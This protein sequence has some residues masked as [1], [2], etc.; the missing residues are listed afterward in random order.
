M[1]LT[2]W[3]ISFFFFNFF[4]LSSVLCKGVCVLLK[5]TASQRPFS[6]LEDHVHKKTRSDYRKELV[7]VESLAILYL[8]F[9][10]VPVCKSNLGHCS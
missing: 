9:C 5:Q 3:E 8:S 1:I 10:E 6:G 2:Q 4:L 7:G